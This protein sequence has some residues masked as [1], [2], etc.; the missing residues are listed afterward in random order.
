MYHKLGY[1]IAWLKYIDDDLKTE[2]QEFSKHVPPFWKNNDASSPLQ[3][4][5]KYL[6]NPGD[7]AEGL[8]SIFRLITIILQRYPFYFCLLTPI[9][10]SY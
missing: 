9:F 2:L 3:F 4:N 8:F 5:G 1:L 10:N 7:V 6:G